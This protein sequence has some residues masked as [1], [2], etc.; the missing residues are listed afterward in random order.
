[1]ILL[2]VL[3]NSLFMETLSVTFVLFFYISFNISRSNITRQNWN[4][5]NHFCTQISTLA[6]IWLKWEYLL[7]WF[8]PNMFLF[9]KSK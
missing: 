5:V 3:S 7:K 1:M 9:S 2:Y 6:V 8:E 4:I